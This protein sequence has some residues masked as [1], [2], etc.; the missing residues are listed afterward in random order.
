VP[1]LLI[2]NGSVRE[3]RVGLPIGEWVRTAAEAD[4]RFDVDYADLA[5][6]R[7][8]FMDEPNHPRLKKYTRPHTLAWSARVEAADAYLLVFPEYN[9]SYSPAIKNAL[10]YLHS[11]WDR[12]PVGFVNWG[13]N[14][15][16]T[17]AQVALRPVVTA[18]G[19]VLTK[20][21]IEINFPQ[22]QVDDDGAFEPTEQQRTV[23]GL[24]L[25][26]MVALDAA[27]APLRG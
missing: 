21:N 26:E 3:G 9:Y 1:R 8:P 5:E 17:R 6:V 11:E 27:L 14:S 15:G 18:L 25:D 20:G 16:G 13:G 4:E 23:L 22:K 24:M 12:K 2:I 10:D 7:L 19:L